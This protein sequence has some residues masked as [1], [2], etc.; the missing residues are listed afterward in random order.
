M[1]LNAST[2]DV[3]SARWVNALRGFTESTMV[4]TIRIYK[5]NAPVY[6]TATDTWSDPSIT[7]YTGKARVQPMRIPRE[8]AQPGD[9]TMISQ[10]QVTIPALNNGLD[11]YAG[12]QV[13]V[14]DSPLNPALLK[15]TLVIVSV[16]DSSNPLERTIHCTMDQEAVL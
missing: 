7:Y 15:Y 8:K 2:T 14:T 9:A 1:V 6:N 10:V 13:K 3:F 12:L 5:P 16:V 11:L 4:A